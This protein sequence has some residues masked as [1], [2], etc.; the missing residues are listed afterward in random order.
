[1]FDCTPSLCHL[2]PLFR[3]L[4]FYEENI[5]APE[6]GGRQYVN[7]ECWKITR[8]HLKFAYLV[9][10]ISTNKQLWAFEILKLQAIWTKLWYAFHSSLSKTMI[11]SYQKITATRDFEAD[12]SILHTIFPSFGILELQNRVMQNDV[13]F[14]LLS[15]KVL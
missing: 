3:L 5:I 2:L 1:M 8:I 4:R 9:K 14:E 6:N 15:R 12:F 10:L 7:D 11:H 13:H